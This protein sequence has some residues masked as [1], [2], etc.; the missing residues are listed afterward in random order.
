MSI[1]LL[2]EKQNPDGGWPYV[3]G[4]S[5]TE[6]TAYAVLA[7][8]GAGERESARRGLR[9]LA[10]LQRSDGGW[11][12]RAGIDESSWATAL[13]ALLPPE[14]LGQGAHARAIRWLAVMTGEEST[15]LYRTR[16]WLLG[17]RRLPEEKFAGWPW[18]PGT[19]AWVAPTAFAILAL[20]KECRRGAS[21]V[22]QNRIEVGRR[23]LL[24]HMCHEGGWNHG[25]VRALGYESRPYPETTGLALA[26]LRGVRSPQVELALTA[27][28]RFFTD[29]R[30]ADA[31]N[32]LRLGLMA[33]EALPE[34]G[35]ARR[36]F[37]CRSVVE[38]SVDLIVARALQGDGVFWSS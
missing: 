29:C 19:A 11:P 21:A 28:R 30:S 4:G 16:E 32:W 18:V 10:S 20:E 36:D 27:A 14:Q 22:L 1:A 38:T 37:Q 5:W 12:A 8:L 3:R 26:A 13:V 17:H 33:H 6:P 7:L 23:Y 25:S 34:A 9:W 35:P 24:V 15:F 2:I 31:F